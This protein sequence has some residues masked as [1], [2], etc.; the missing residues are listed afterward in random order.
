MCTRFHPLFFLFLSTNTP[1][2]TICLCRPIISTFFSTLFF[3]S[4]IFIPLFFFFLLMR[5]DGKWGKKIIDNRRLRLVSMQVSCSGVRSLDIKKNERQLPMVVVVD[6]HFNI[7][8]NRLADIYIRYIQYRS[9]F[10]LPSC[11]PKKM[12]ATEVLYA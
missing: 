11:G 7:K 2:K 5:R 1:P 3:L 9:S 10:F 6:V 4:L 8:M 12:T